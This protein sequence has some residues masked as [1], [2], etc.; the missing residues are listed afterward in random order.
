MENYVNKNTYAE[1]IHLSTINDQA[2]I[3]GLIEKLEDAEQSSTATMDF[4]DPDYKIIIKDN[5]KIINDLGY[6]E[7][8]I[9]LGVE[10]RYLNQE[11][12]RLYAVTVKLPLVQ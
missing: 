3:I 1:G 2:F 11:E 5:Q 12:E 9:K 4:Q 6:Y 8:A 7:G 10:G